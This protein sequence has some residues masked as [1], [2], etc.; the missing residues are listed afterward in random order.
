MSAPVAVES[1]AL[2]APISWGIP[3][4]RGVPA[5]ARARRVRA[6]RRRPMAPGAEASAVQTSSTIHGF[7]TQV[8]SYPRTKRPARATAPRAD[9]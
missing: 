7:H 1:F 5:H 3:P 2:F 4:L 6:R 8:G 9:A